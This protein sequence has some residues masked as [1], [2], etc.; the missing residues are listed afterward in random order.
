MFLGYV[1]DYD[2]RI[3]KFFIN[4]YDLLSGPSI[5][6]VSLYKDYDYI[7]SHFFEKCGGSDKSRSKVVGKGKNILLGGLCNGVLF[8]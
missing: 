6:S 7:V 5:M 4:K 1:V 8:V 2:Y 3:L